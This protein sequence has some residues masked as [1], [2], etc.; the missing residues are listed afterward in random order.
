M[1]RRR[2][3]RQRRAALAPPQSF[4]GVVAPDVDDAMLHEIAQADY[5]NDADEHW[6]ALRAIRDDLTVPCPLTWHP[7]EVLELI[8]WSEPEDPAWSPGSVGIR[9]HTM[10]AFCCAALLLAAS[11]PCK[12]EVAEIDTLARAVESALAL[13]VAYEQACLEF[14]EWRMRDFPLTEE[15]P[16]FGLAH[17]LLTIR[18]SR[19]VELT[20]VCGLARGVVADEALL[21]ASPGHQG[22]ARWLLGLTFFDQSHHCWHR[23]GDELIAAAAR[24]LT[25]QAAIEVRQIGERLLAG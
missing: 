23:L 21:R 12:A 1:S 19:A 17:L 11:P 22:G 5:G 13:G 14:L 20:R 25:G 16:F 15:R 24:G 9:G 2:R 10:R 6:A 8:R 3:R 4:L 7:G 18:T